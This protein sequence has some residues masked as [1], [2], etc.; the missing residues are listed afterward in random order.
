VIV[1]GRGSDRFVQQHLLTAT[2]YYISQGYYPQLRNHEMKQIFYF[3]DI[4]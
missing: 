3:A 2:M 1:L 4:A